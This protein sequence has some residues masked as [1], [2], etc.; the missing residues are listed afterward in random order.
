MLNLK[1]LFGLHD[2][3][4][5]HPSCSKLTRPLYDVPQSRECKICGKIQYRTV[6]VL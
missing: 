1:C 4:V 5:W 6:D 2:F 3:R